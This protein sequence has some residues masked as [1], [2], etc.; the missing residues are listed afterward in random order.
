MRSNSSDES[1]ELAERYRGFYETEDLRRFGR[2]VMPKAF[3]VTSRWIKA[4]EVGQRLGI[5]VELGCGTGPLSQVH[6][7]YVGLEFSRTA[8]K[9]VRAGVRT[10]NADMQMLP[11]RSNS[12]GFIFSWAAIE[13]VPHPERVFEEISRV[14]R[15]G[16]VALLA[17]AW[18]CRPWA[19]KGLPVRDYR[20]L[21]WRSRLEK[22]TIP[23]RNT[24]W[25]RAL[26]AAP[27]RFAGEFRALAREPLPFHY[28]RLTPNLTDYVYTDCDAFTSMDPHAAILY[29]ATRGWNILSHPSWAARML[30]RHEPIVVKKP[31]A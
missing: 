21:D 24:L 2:E 27:A 18:H 9:A 30:S 10:V 7:D 31:Q 23:I 14:L 4:S 5:I 15:P 16:G 8:L 1:R 29:F 17:P 11:F 13:H 28:R 20:E 25:W 3:E 19:S 12:V 6:P 22:L 26:W